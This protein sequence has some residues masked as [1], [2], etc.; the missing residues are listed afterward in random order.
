[1]IRIAVVDDDK[2]ICKQLSDSLTKY[3]VQENIEFEIESFYDCE[4]LIQRLESKAVF[5]LYFLDIEFGEKMNG[6]QFGNYLRD[7]IISMHSTIIFISSMESYAK[8]LFRIHPFDF[9]VKPLS[10]NNIKTTLDSFFKMYYHGNTN[11]SFTKNKSLHNISVSKVTFLE[12]S[13]KKIIIHMH[14]DTT[15]FYGKLSDYIDM[16]C[17]SDFVM[18]HKSYFVNTK[19]IDRFGYNY[20][21]LSDNTQLPISR[22]YQDDVRDRL[23]NI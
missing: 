4:T 7:S 3:S 18:I 12:S 20:V 17:F 16:K 22:A 9:L 23:M 10:F 14:G 13:G 11:F 21:V 5:D 1:M 2:T 19:A 8:E 6:M 15:D